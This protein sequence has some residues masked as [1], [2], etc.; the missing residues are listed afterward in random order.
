MLKLPRIPRPRLTGWP[1]PALPSSVR[2]RIIAGF[3]LLVI[4]LAAVV[5][6]SAWLERQH[7]WDLKDV[8]EL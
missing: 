2:A 3:A 6:G 8:E 5:A 7:R 1:K 4:I